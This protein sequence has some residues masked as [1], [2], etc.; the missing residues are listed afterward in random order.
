MKS[1]DGGRLIR[2]LGA[3]QVE[4]LSRW[5]RGWPGPPIAVSGVPGNVYATGDG[6]FIGECRAGFEATSRDRLEDFA[7]RLARGYRRVSR[8]RATFDVG[9]FSSLT[10]LLSEGLAKRQLAVFVKPASSGGNAGRPMMLWRVGGNY[11]PAGSGGAA[12][13]GGTV[14]NK[15][16][17]GCLVYND[18][19]AGDATFVGRFMAGSLNSFQGQPLTVMLSDRLFSVAKTMSSTVIEA[20][21]GVPTRYTSTTP[22]DPDYCGGNYVAI[23]C[24]SNLPNTAHNW[25]V[26][27]YTNQAGTTGQSFPSA[28]GLNAN[29][30]TIGDMPAGSFFLPFA[31][32]DTGVKALTQMQCDT[33]I[34]GGIDFTINHPLAWVGCP[35]ATYLCVADG[36]RTSFN[37]A[38]VFDNACL[39]LTLMCTAGTSAPI[40]GT[41]ELLQG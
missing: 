25:T 15:S 3:A 17:T 13:P 30:T 9:G 6:D 26:C 35:V 4:S 24:T 40:S 1:T 21:T 10:D 41:L 22:T 19:I 8:R 28:A 38:R 7:R 32:G 33:S 34:T 37:L 29:I 2:W 31:A 5:N 14:Y 27:Q 20:V 36:I 23:E 16:S 12:A 18:A 11:P 39:S